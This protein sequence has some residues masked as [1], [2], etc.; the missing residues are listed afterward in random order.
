[1]VGIKGKSFTAAALAEVG[2][3]RISL[4]T[5]LYRAAITALIAATTEAKANGTFSFVDTAITTIEF[6]R[7]MEE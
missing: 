5:S 6:N 2:V 7:Y 3:R 4:A 1:M